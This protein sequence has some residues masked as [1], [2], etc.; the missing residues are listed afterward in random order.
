MTQD[1]GYN[2]CQQP[3]GKGAYKKA[4]RSNA[5][6]NQSFSL[7]EDVTASAFW[8]R[9]HSFTTLN[10]ADITLHVQLPLRCISLSKVM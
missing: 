5:S 1:N 7:V 3:K 4:T 2:S 10:L 6:T 9:T 8:L